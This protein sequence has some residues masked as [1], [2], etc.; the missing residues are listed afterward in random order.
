MTARSS[1]GRARWLRPARSWFNSKRAGL[2]AI[3]RP[4]TRWSDCF[5]IWS[6]VLI[7][8]TTGV[9]RLMRRRVNGQ[10]RYRRMTLDEERQFERDEAW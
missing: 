3:L 8:G 10:W 5:C 7:D 9:G 6:K 4:D 2:L 1:T